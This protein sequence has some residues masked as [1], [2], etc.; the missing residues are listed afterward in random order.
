MLRLG[1][2]EKQMSKCQMLCCRELVGTLEIM[3]GELGRIG[4]WLR[5]W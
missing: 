2:G 1:L 3:P 5:V 4:V